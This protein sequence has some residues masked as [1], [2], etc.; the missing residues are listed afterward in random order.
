MGI[1]ENEACEGGYLYVWVNSYRNSK[2]YNQINKIQLH[3][4]TFSISESMLIKN[5][6]L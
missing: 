6:K 5:S 4:F 3:S 1:H 2:K